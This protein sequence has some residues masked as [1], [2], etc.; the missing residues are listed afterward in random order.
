MY[1]ALNEDVDE[2]QDFL[3]SVSSHTRHSRDFTQAGSLGVKC[4]SA[5]NLET[6][7]LWIKLHYK[8]A[9]LYE[10]CE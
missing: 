2:D 5:N 1:N 10:G 8:W 9:D 7:A 4:E 6:S 3:T